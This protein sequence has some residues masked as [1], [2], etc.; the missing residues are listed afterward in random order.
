MGNSPTVEYEVGMQVDARYDGNQTAYFPAKI[1]KKHEYGRYD[2]KFTDTA[3]IITVFWDDIKPSYHSTPQQTQHTNSPNPHHKRAEISSSLNE[4]KLQQKLQENL[5]NGVYDAMPTKVFNISLTSPHNN[6]NND[7]DHAAKNERAWNEFVRTFDFYL[8]RRRKIQLELETSSS[9]TSFDLTHLQKFEQLLFAMGGEPLCRDVI[10]SKQ[11]QA[12]QYI[13]ERIQQTA[14]DKNRKPEHVQAVQYIDKLKHIQI[15]PA[16]HASNDSD[17]VFSKYGL[18][19]EISM[20]LDYDALVTES[21]RE[22]FR[23]EVTSEIASVLNVHPS[24]VRVD[25]MRKGSVIISVGICAVALVLIVFGAWSVCKLKYLVSK[26]R[27]KKLSEG[28]KLLN[29]CIGDQVVVDYEQKEYDAEVVEKYENAKGAWVKVAYIDKPFVF[30]NTEK[31]ELSSPRLRLKEPGFQ[32]EA[33]L[34]PREGGNVNFEILPI[35]HHFN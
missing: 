23:D 18:R 31:I 33:V 14:T 22:Q 17:D 16:Q 4:S 32:Y 20:D 6:N 7:D 26:R 5:D 30:Q 15:L 24:L 9:A 2:V 34:C 21:N 10:L 11:E 19:Y 3:K 28:E 13:V 12:G 8:R 35:A 29:V 1:I 25:A 27:T